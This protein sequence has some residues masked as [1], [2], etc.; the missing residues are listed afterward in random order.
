MVCLGGE[1]IGVSCQAEWLADGKVIRLAAEEGVAVT[2]SCRIGDR[3]CAGAA[4][5]VVPVGLTARR[6]FTMPLFLRDGKLVREV[7]GDDEGRFRLPPLAPGEYQLQLHP[8]GGR[9]V[10]GEPFT[11]PAAASL[12][13]AEEPATKPVELELGEIQLADGA[14]IEVRVTD[15]Y[16]APV[17]GAGVGARQGEEIENLAFFETATN[18]E[19]HAQLAGLEPAAATVVTCVA[20][21]Y[22]RLEQSFD[23]PPPWVDC[24]LE[25]LAAVAGSVQDPD[26]QAIGGAAISIGSSQILATSESDGSF[27]VADL[28]AGDYDLTIAAPGWRSEELHLELAAGEKRQLQPVELLPGAA[29]EGVVLDAAGEPVAGAQL[30]ALLPAG[31]VSTVT[32]SL[33]EFGFDV[34]PDVALTLEISA[35]GYP[36]VQRALAP[37]ELQSGDPIEIRLTAGG[38]I[39]VTVWDEDSGE[40][41]VG[42]AV[43]VFGPSRNVPR[44]D[45][46]HTGQ[47]LSPPLA[48]G[49]YQVQRVEQQSRGAVI[50]VRGG[51]DLQLVDLHAGELKEV[52]FGA[53]RSV[54]RLR[55]TPALPLG[56][57]L[58]AASGGEIRQLAAAADGSFPLRRRAG[59]DTTLRLEGPDSSQVLLAQIA[60]DFPEDHLEVTL[61]D[62]GL[63]GLLLSPDGQPLSR[64]LVFLNLATTARQAA[65]HSRADGSFDLPILQPGTYA[66]VS[67]DIS[68]RVVSVPR[69]RHQD[70]G[71]VELAP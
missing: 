12:R 15:A 50:T 35:D 54:L 16:G 8:T 38:R 31:A 42:C 14:R 32:D 2:G 39:R 29:V 68:L 21:G 22:R 24:A 6:P 60:A 1:G 27:R 19:G 49:T 46:D 33:G 40:P 10:L 66:L 59:E 53:P 56:W 11:V 18:A 17:D 45:T 7:S 41:C 65:T 63:H 43:T 64:A 9:L 34:N 20:K 4:V 3:P 58:S 67:E 30:T 69:G 52:V 51:H 36:S 44:L 62:A 61:P 23:V 13:D 26:G 48:A 71:I 37:Q 55:L 5:A 28:I 70:L 47:A 25:A 57:S